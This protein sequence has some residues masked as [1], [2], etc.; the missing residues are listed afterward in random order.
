[1]AD[2]RIPEGYAPV[3]TDDRLNPRRAEQSVAG[4]T[5][6]QRTKTLEIPRQAVSASGPKRIKEPRIVPGV[7]VRTRSPQ[8]IYGSTTQAAKAERAPKVA[9]ATQIFVQVG[10]FRDAAQARAGAQRMARTGLPTRMGKKVR[11][12]T[13]IQLVLAGPFASRAQAQQA[14]QAARRAGFANAVVMN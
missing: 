8:I 7:T 11:G 6:S 14:V 13:Q 2:V 5:Q 9:P 1:M 3:W 10:Q 4:Y 12:A